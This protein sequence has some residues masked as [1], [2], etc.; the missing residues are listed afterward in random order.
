MRVYDREGKDVGQVENVYLGSVSEKA[1]EYGQG[2]AT[3][4]DPDLPGEGSLINN[5]VEAFT[6]EDELPEVMR[7]RLLR[8]GFIRI[9]GPGWFASDRYVTPDKIASVSD[10]RVYLSVAQN[11]LI[12]AR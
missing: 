6:F 9:D 11:E 4:D 12:K 1:D 7:N 8:Q 3:A 5:I 10:G 2:P